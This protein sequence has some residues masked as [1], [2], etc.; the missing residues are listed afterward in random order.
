MSVDFQRTT[1][2]YIAEVEPLFTGNQDTIHEIPVSTKKQN[3]KEEKKMPQ[4]NTLHGIP[5]TNI[6][7]YSFYGPVVRVPGYKSTDP[8]FD[9][10]CYQIF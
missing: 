4:H 5:N 2:R 6:K 10:R 9:S 3:R 8:G 7:C 1:R